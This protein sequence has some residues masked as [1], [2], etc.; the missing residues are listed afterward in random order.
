M[1]VARKI[2]FLHFNLKENPELIKKLNAVAPHEYLTVHALAQRIMLQVL[3]QRI[4]E[5]G[6]PQ[7]EYQPAACAV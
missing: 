4:I 7:S 3:N 2:E 1:A 5:L 6:I